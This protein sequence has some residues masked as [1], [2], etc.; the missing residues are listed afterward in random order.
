MTSRYDFVIVGGG[1]AAS[2]VANPLSED[3]VTRGLVLVR[4]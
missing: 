2:A 3:P 1:S 4:L